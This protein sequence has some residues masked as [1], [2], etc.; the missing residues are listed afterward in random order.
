MGHIHMK[1][2]YF[3]DIS[4]RLIFH[5]RWKNFVLQWG[6]EFSLMNAT[7]D[8]KYWRNVGVSINIFRKMFIGRSRN[9]ENCFWRNSEILFLNIFFHIMKQYNETRL[10]Y[11][12]HPFNYDDDMLNN[13]FQNPWNI[14]TK[15]QQHI[16]L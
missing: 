10:R 12:S 16:N 11:F 1:T 6:L 3:F 2:H 5:R 15:L 13:K 14:Y 9:S 8:T 4:S 7:Y